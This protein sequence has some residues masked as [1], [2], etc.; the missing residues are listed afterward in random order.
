MNGEPIL[1][2]QSPEHHFD[3]KNNDWYWMLGI[4]TLG[5]SVLAF[6]FGDFLFGVFLIIAGATVGMLSYKE[7][8][9]ISVKITPKGIVFGR[10]LH[11][12]LSYRSFWIEDEHV[13]GP[14]ILL[15]ST[16]SYLPLTII[17]INEWIDLNE[18]RDILLEF[19]EE[20]PL[21]E[22]VI[23]VWFDKL[24]AKW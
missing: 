13:N 1:E 7:T 9:A 4:I 19:L 14:R 10:Y 22:S 21:R 16:R 17:P 18:V 23:H 8:K 3:K 24:I 15:H 12:W 20:E 5:A 11:P 2:W 6:Y